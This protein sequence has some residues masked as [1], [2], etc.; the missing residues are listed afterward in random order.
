M[1]PQTRTQATRLQLFGV[2]VLPVLPCRLVLYGTSPAT[3]A[4][5]A[6]RAVVSAVALPAITTTLA[7]TTGTPRKPDAPGPCG[8]L[9]A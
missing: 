7:L 3:A 1:Q 5:P 4:P 8:L 9:V 2:L 6:L